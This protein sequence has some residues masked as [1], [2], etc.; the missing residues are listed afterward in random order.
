MYICDRCG[1]STENKQSYCSHRSHCKLD[2][3]GNIIKRGFGK[4]GSKVWNKGL[5]KDSDERVKQCGETL[6]NKYNSGELI[7][8]NKGKKYSEERCKQ[9][10][11]SRKEFL[12]LHP[13]K[14]PYVISH[15]S[16]GD[17]YP[18]RY[19]KE[20]FN[21]NNIKYEQNYYC[22]GFFLDFAWPD[23]KIYLE[24]DGEQHYKDERIVRHDEYRTKLLSDNGWNCL[25]RL[26]WTWYQS[27]NKNERI[28]YIN[29]LVSKL[30][31]IL[32][33]P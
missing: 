19:F 7:H 1:Y 33:L 20:V 32:K 16:K 27:L 2:E 6:S 17:S 12:K 4:L 13:E 22:L 21:N 18:E 3:N 26:R 11:E 10:S 28:D 15:H 30:N 23:K 24:I 31:S 14:V 29:S 25:V 9:I 5:T 8:Y